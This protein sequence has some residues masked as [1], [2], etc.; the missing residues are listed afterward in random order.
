MG[1]ITLDEYTQHD[2]LGLAELVRRKEV[3]AEEL[4][5]VA[6]SAIEQIDPKI[7]AVVIRLYDRARE[8]IAA[9]LPEGPFTGVPFLLKGT[10]YLHLIAGEMAAEDPIADVEDSHGTFPCVRKRFALEKGSWNLFLFFF[11]SGNVSPCSY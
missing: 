9:G 1:S 8:G 11:P 7:N 4:L 6:I 2:A 10:G 3:Q 5:E